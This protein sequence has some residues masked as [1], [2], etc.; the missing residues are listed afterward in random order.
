MEVLKLTSTSFPTT[1]RPFASPGHF[2][3]VSVWHPPHSYPLLS[4]AFARISV[5]LRLLLLL[6]SVS[7][8]SEHGDVQ[9]RERTLHRKWHN[10][11]LERNADTHTSHVRTTSHA[12]RGRLKYA[13][14][15]NR[16]CTLRAIDDTYAKID[17]PDTT[18]AAN[19]TNY[20]AIVDVCLCVTS[21]VVAFFHVSI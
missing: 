3:C 17:T 20:P 13:N 5:L 9:S 6:R 7:G 14:L 10:F 18:V 16:V 15:A 4:F 21:M 12:E 2:L 19:E 1:R 11:T 8:K